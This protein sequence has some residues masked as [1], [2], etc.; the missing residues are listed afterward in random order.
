MAALDAVGLTLT[1]VAAVVLAVNGA[2]HPGWWAAL[3]IAILAGAV[4]T[5][6][7]VW[8]LARRRMFVANVNAV[9]SRLESGGQAVDLKFARTLRK[10]A[11]NN[12]DLDLAGRLEAATESH[13]TPV[14][15]SGGNRRIFTT[16]TH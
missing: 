8:L 13:A 2:S 1:T 16:A 10:H 5:V 3:A 14:V 6:L 4:T 12:A 7:L 11:S 9:A 15:Q